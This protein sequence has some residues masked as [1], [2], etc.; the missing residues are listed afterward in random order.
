M[1]AILEAR[2]G[3]LERQIEVLYEGAMILGTDKLL[4]MGA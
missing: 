1:N 4:K 3:K 2:F